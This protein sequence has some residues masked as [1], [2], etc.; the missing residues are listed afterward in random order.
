MSIRIH[1]P[2]FY[3]SDANEEEILAENCGT[4][5]ECM[6]V[7]IRRYP[8]LGNMLFD[9]KGKLQTWVGI[10]VDGNDAFPN[11]LAKPVKDG[12]EIRLF[13]YLSV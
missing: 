3:R 1:V 8:D 12:D 9:R 7:I 5:G 13:L 6:S 4:V 11:E 10:Y 2:I